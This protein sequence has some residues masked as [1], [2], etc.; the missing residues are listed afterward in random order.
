[1]QVFMDARFKFLLLLVE[2]RNSSVLEVET[3]RDITHLQIQVECLI[4]CVRQ[5]YTIL[6]KTLPIDYLITSNKHEIPTLDKSARVC[7]GLTN[8]SESLISTS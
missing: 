4:G 6:E 5:K 7:C 1:M 8:L 3:T 2:S